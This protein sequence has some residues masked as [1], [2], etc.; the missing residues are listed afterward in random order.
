LRRVVGQRAWKLE[1]REAWRQE[2]LKA[3]K[4]GGLEAFFQL[5]GFPAS[6]PSGFLA[7]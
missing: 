5:P 4:L 3:G 2:G 1:G 6:Q 7:I